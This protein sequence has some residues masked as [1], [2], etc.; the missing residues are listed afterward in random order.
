MANIDA[1]GGDANGPVA[2]LA[3]ITADTDARE[4]GDLYRR[5]KR[6]V[7]D[8]VRYSLQAGDRLNK[9]KEK[10]GHGKWLPWLEANA[11][12][13][14]FANPGTAQRLMQ[15]ASKYRVDAVFEDEAEAAAICREMWGNSE[16]KL[17]K[18]Q[19]DDEDHEEPEVWPVAG[20]K[21]FQN[22]FDAHGEPPPAGDVETVTTSIDTKGR[23]QPARKRERR[24]R[25]SKRKQ[26][27]QERLHRELREAARR[28][29]DEC[30]QIVALLVDRLGVDT[31]TMIYAAFMAG[32]GE[33][34]LDRIMNVP[35]TYGAEVFTKGEDYT[36]QDFMFKY[37]SP[38][39]VNPPVEGDG[40]EGLGERG[41]ITGKA[42]AEV[43]GDDPFEIPPMLRRTGAAP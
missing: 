22:P 37:G 3:V 20:Q 8:S 9:K 33:L 23:K 6:S 31:L 4:I 32:A 1:S 29:E 28:R 21:T 16:R 18:P 30:E 42:A 39:S 27:E 38:K 43:N 7:V 5:A 2:K 36:F 13:L 25:I 15:V 10:L 11:D 40:L 14:G 19:R 12:A 24:E 26:E 41:G 35:G 17:P 34:Y